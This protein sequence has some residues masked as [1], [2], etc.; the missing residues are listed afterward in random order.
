MITRQESHRWWSRKI[1]FDETSGNGVF[2][3]AIRTEAVVFIF[4]RFSFLSILNFLVRL[5]KDFHWRD[6]S[7]IRLY[8]MVSILLRYYGFTKDLLRNPQCTHA[9]LHCCT[10]LQRSVVVQ[11][12]PILAIFGAQNEWFGTFWKEWYF[13]ISTAHRL[14]P[15]DSIENLIDES[16]SIGTTCTHIISE[17]QRARWNQRR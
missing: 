9:A 15:G 16:L 13:A 10:V 4:S 12:I 3:V 2:G 6:L 1:I 17:A 8:R 5:P 11:N 7:L 14:R